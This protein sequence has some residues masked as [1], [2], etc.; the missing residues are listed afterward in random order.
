MNI[1]ARRAYIKAVKERYNKSSKKQKTQILNELCLNC[2]YSRKHAIRPL[3]S[4]LIGQ[5]IL[6]F[7]R[8]VGTPRKYSKEAGNRLVELWQFMNYPCSINLKQALVQWLPYDLNTPEVIKRELLAMSESTIERALK[9]TKHKRPKGKST[10]HPPKIKSQ[11]PL[12]LCKDD[13]KKSIG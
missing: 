7:K 13:D 2:G 3:N 1:E 5:C 9:A 8:P 10:T 11:I 6:P 4:H 12:K